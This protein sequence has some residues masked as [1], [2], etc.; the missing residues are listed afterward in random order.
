[1]S[2]SLDEPT[3]HAYVKLMGLFEGGSVHWSGLYQE[4]GAPALIEMIEGG[5]F[6][7]YKK[8]GAKIGRASCRERV[9]L[10]V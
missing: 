1:M 5:S 2:Q 10:Y 8:I 7:A 9:C 3:L 6:S 4:H